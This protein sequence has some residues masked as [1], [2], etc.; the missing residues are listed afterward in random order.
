MSCLQW[1]AFTAVSSMVLASQGCNTD[2]VPPNSLFFLFP[3]TNKKSYGLLL[4]HRQKETST[5]KF[6]EIPKAAWEL[7]LK[8]FSRMKGKDERTG[9]YGFL[10]A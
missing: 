8:P 7:E 3:K 2:S 9:K 6:W 5:E 4:F 10:F 1:C